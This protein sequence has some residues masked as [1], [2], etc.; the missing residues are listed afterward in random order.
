MAPTAQSSRRLFS[1]RTLLMPIC[2]SK[3]PLLRTPV[4][5]GQGTHP[6][7]LLATYSLFKA[8]PTN[9]HRILPYRGLGLRRINA[10]DAV[11]F[12]TQ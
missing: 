12:S 6:N 9:N 4:R 3:F 1:T 5:L 11:R 2:V 10:R 8:L 7:R